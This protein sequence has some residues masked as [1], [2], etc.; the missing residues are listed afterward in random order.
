[1]E[2]YQL[3]ILVG[4]NIAIFMGMLSTIVTFH[5]YSNKQIAES[6]RDLA[7]SNKEF[8]EKIYA[9]NEKSRSYKNVGRPKGAKNKK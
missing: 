3:I 1:M 4:T 9:L 7:A 2:N 5:I 8:N 6:R